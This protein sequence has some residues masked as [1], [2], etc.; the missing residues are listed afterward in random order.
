M[1]RTTITIILMLSLVFTATITVY[2]PEGVLSAFNENSKY[3]QDMNLQ[4]EIRMKGDN[5]PVIQFM[6]RSVPDQLI[7][8]SNTF[9]ST[10]THVS[11]IDLSSYQ[12][13]GWTLYE[14]IIVQ[15]NITAI[16]EKEVIG[17]NA[18]SPSDLFAIYEH[19]SGLYYDQLAQGFYN[20]IHDGQLQNLS[21]LYQTPTYDP[22]FH[23]Y[24]YLDIRS[25]YQDGTSNMVSSVPLAYVGYTGTWANV[26]ENVIL[27]GGVTY[28]AVING[29]KL[30]QVPGDYPKIR[31][32]YQD[33]S[34]TFLTRRHNTDGDTWG[35]DRPYE[36]LLNYSYI[37]WNTTTNSALVYTDPTTI[38]LN[39]NG[40]P[41]GGISWSVS[42]ASSIE[43]IEINTNQS[44]DVYYNLT[45]SYKKDVT[46][47]THWFAE[48][49]S[50]SIIWNVT[51]N[52]TY[53][54]VPETVTHFMNITGIPGDWTTTGLYLGNTPAGSQ[55]KIG[56]TVYCTGLSD[57]TWT[58]TSSAPNYVT[59]IVLSD[60]SDSSPIGDLVSLL[61]IM[62][63]DATVEDEI[64]TPISGGL[65]NLTITHGGATIYAPLEIAASSG[66]VSF[67]WNISSTT[68]GNGTHLIEIYW[69]NGLEAG[70]YT[71]QVFV[72]YPTTLVADEYSISAFT[73]NSFDIGVDFNQIYPVRGLDDTL[74]DVTYS[75]GSIVNATLLNPSGGRWEQTID[76]TG[77][78]S[79]TYPLII[80]A[81]GYTIENQS[82]TI[83]VE[84]I[85]ETLPL[86]W[87]WSQGNNIT[88]L[89]STNLTV[90]YWDINS[91]S[92]PD[93]MVNVTFDGHTYALQWDPIAEVY[94]IQL[95]GTDFL[96]VPGTTLLN[97]SAWKIGYAPQYNDSIE[98]SI[99]PET[100]VVF[101]VDW[102]PADRNITYIESIAI[103]VTY[104]YNSV[105]IDGAWVRA[106]FSGH[107]LVNFTYNSGLG[108]WELILDGS[109]YFGIT[110]ITVRAS[111]TGYSLVQE[112]QT[113]TV[114]ED[115]PTVSGSWIEDA[116][117]TDYVTNIPLL[118]TIRDSSGTFIND[119]T[120]TVYV[121]STNFSMVFV[122]DGVYSITIDPIEIQGIHQVNVTMERT[123][124]KTSSILLELTI[125]ATT[126]IEVDF[127]QSEYEQWNLTITVTYTD[128]FYDT[129]VEDA[130][131]TITLDGV[132]YTLDYSEGVYVIEIVLDVDPGV[133]TISVNA[134]SLFCN[135]ASTSSSLTVL[136]KAGVYL[137]LATEGDP[138]VQ[139]QLL[140]II[141]T[142][143]YNDTDLPVTNVNIY[144]IVTIYY[145]NG[146]IELRNSP[147]Q[148][149]TTNDAGVAS[150]GFQIPAGTIDRIEV[151]AEF[152]GS[153]DKWT[154]SLSQVVAVASNPILLVISFLFFTNIGRLIV[155]SIA[156]LAVVAAGYNKSVKPKKRAFRTS[157]ENQLE[158]FKDL[159]SLRHFM[160]IYL[161]RGT[162][163]FYH[164][165][166]DERI[167]P[168][169]IS[170]FIAAITSVYGEIKGDGV[171]GT[172][173]EIQYH[174][175]RLNS[176]SGE[177]IIGI[178]ILEGEMTPLLRERLQFFI[179]LFENQ[180]DQDLTGWSG[181][182][183][184]FDPEWVVS[185]L[186]STFNYS[187]LLPH[188]FGPTQKVNKTNARILDYIGAV[189]DER[190]EF[191]LKD[192]I[193]P[194]AEMF[195]KS[196]A[197]IL[198]KLLQLQERGMIA[199][200][201]IQ[202]ILQRQ[203]MGLADS[204][205]EG[206]TI[207]LPPEIMKEI[208]KTPEE[209]PA[210]E[211][212][213]EEEEQQEPEDQE[214]SEEPAEPVIEKEPSKPPK[215][216]VDPLEEF[217]RDVEDLLTKEKEKEE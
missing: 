37:P 7:S 24:A 171:R 10:T 79:G 36:A 66:L 42:S 141:A 59:D 50:S 215:K 177:F 91:V 154:A 175:L 207:P 113:L 132:V 85:I 214:T 136:P 98:I 63:I 169:L 101:N 21:I 53:P 80:Y 9:G 212:I 191:Y 56:T 93:A 76:T 139:G 5:I 127:Q 210:E 137:S 161:D 64:G 31:W 135:E 118:I 162:C 156:I 145:T 189:R 44:V 17:V 3:L 52:L 14:V 12:I 193:K 18:E 160:A 148:Y 15:D 149:D 38:N 74:V 121:F 131:V 122:G 16:I 173:E 151:L 170:G 97:V 129:P 62:D 142:L 105:P 125:S 26:T 19:E 102:N 158:M 47:I 201:S 13:P 43:Q 34:G 55:T 87:S 78:S 107:P 130:T 23:N 57:G 133:Y 185:T 112:T 126:D 88:Y 147:T 200:V 22:G 194:L 115:I 27:D 71:T 153:R 146:T 65:A 41:M 92:I 25:N 123:G 32:Y 77:M 68:S 143:Q 100:G 73:D 86:N 155:I 8:I 195:E 29:T 216:M 178:L 144:F 138:S 164:P 187:W 199:P 90:S 28:Y 184:C 140:S 159:E 181:L 206:I 20:Q 103:T 30:N 81:E 95:N 61:V 45:L 46:A 67:S 1:R 35:S 167:Q 198:D 152:R 205:S 157:L 54:V 94:W 84:L 40:T 217:V 72:Y 2:A 188:R 150:W 83:S 176:Y 4:A 11:S 60:S 165:F 108:V 58:L 172:L 197:E 96:V 99:S 111:A 116:A 213:I 39:L 192:L 124:F 104:T 82:L 89:D 166:T 203:G 75:F 6:H 134:N 114:I 120:V 33:L 117:S 182:I 202:T 190:G 70:Y 211:E 179:E 186:N 180:Y 174:G 51:V 128:S 69:I 110:T 106:T 183:D 168:D 208:D 163:V 109:D 196:E 49:L 48:S 119:A 209:E 204:D